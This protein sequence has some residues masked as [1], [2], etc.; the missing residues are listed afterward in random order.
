MYPGFLCFA[1]TLNQGKERKERESV[2][3]VT[4][5]QEKAKTAKVR[6]EHEVL[7]AESRE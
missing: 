1:V 2:G 3:K 5:M 4:V 6:L 7:T